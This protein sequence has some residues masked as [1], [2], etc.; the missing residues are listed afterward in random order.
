MVE[1]EQLLKGYL[2]YSISLIYS[3]NKNLVDKQEGMKKYW[4]N[5]NQITEKFPSVTLHNGFDFIIDRLFILRTF[6]RAHKL[7]IHAKFVYETE[8]FKTF[9]TFFILI[10]S[11]KNKIG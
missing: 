5:I 4:A 3:L 8:R 10:M 1:T 11:G 2:G 6:Q 9:Q 7:F